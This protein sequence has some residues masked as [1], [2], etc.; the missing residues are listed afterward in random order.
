MGLNIKVSLGKVKKY[1]NKGLKILLK[2]VS[3]AL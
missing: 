3:T 2:I 1:F